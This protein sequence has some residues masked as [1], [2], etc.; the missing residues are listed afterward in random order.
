MSYPIPEP[1]EDQR[2]HPDSMPWVDLF[3]HPPK[4][5]VIKRPHL[6]GDG[7]DGRAVP[8]SA[9]QG[10]SVTGDDAHSGAPGTTRRP[11]R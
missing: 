1:V 8:F 7:V 6:L 11:P 9:V 5:E 2:V 10:H 3:S 4:A